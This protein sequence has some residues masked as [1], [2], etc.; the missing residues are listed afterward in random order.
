MNSDNHF[1]WVQD[2]PRARM[3][4]RVSFLLN[5]QG[6][7]YGSYSGSRA[8]QDLARYFHLDVRT[9]DEPNWRGME[10]NSPACPKTA[11]R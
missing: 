10:A 6:A 5:D 11:S 1:T 7:N 8:A 2:S 3:Q 4:A 9:H